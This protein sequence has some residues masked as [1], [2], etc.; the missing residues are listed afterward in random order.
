CG[1]MPRCGAPPAAG[2]S[3]RHSRASITRTPHPPSKS[4]AATP[5]WILIKSHSPRRL[6][7][8]IPSIELFQKGPLRSIGCAERE[9][10]ADLEV[11]EGFSREP[12]DWLH[13][14]NQE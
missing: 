7:M 10:S 4:Q 11:S 3:A 8:S 12:A 14:C 6:R 13:Q 2:P 5:R 1:E 9:Y